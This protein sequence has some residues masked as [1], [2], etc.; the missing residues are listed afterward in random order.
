ML[1]GG[2]AA[3]ARFC[4]MTRVSARGPC[5]LMIQPQLASI[6]GDARWDPGWPRSCEGVNPSQGRDI[7]RKFARPGNAVSIRP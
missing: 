5:P 3:G 2:D 6:I 4:V 1:S 7:C